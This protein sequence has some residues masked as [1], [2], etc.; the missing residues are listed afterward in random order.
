MKNLKLKFI[1]TLMLLTISLASI[2]AEKREFVC[3]ADDRFT[4]EEFSGKQFSLT[5]S[6]TCI[7]L[8][9][10]RNKK[11]DWSWKVSLKNSLGDVEGSRHFCDKPDDGLIGAPAIFRMSKMKFIVF[12]EIRF[13]A[14]FSCEKLVEK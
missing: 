3:I 10:L 8:I 1:I 2:G 12:G 5:V 4:S 6:S 14:S 7:N 13:N 11:K 9:N